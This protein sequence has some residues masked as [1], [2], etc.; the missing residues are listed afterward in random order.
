VYLLWWWNKWCRLFFPE[1]YT[2]LT[3]PE[4]EKVLLQANQETGGLVISGKD[5]RSSRKEKLYMC[6]EWSRNEW[7]AG[8]EDEIPWLNICWK[9]GSH[10]ME[11]SDWK[12]ETGQERCQKRLWTSPRPVLLIICYRFR[13]IHAYRKLLILPTP[14]LFDAPARGDLLEFLADAAK[15]TINN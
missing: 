9:H 15:V 3:D 14:P 4:A 6:M 10:L 11:R 12:R 2:D 5:F 13:D 8:E 7:S 1:G